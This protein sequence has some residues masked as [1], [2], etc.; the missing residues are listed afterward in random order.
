M[1]S[2]IY[3][4]SQSTTFTWTL[5]EGTYLITLWC[6]KSL[7][8]FPSCNH[9]FE[10]PV[11][12][13]RRHPS[14]WSRIWL[15]Y[16]FLDHAPTA[17]G[18]GYQLLK[19]VI[20]SWFSWLLLKTDFLAEEFS[21]LRINQWCTKV[22]NI[23]GCYGDLY[24]FSTHDKP[25]HNVIDYTLHT[26]GGTVSL[27]DNNIVLLYTCRKQPESAVSEVCIQNIAEWE[28]ATH[29]LPNLVYRRLHTSVWRYKVENTKLQV[30]SL[31]AWWYQNRTYTNNT[32]SLAITIV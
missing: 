2:H 24:R 23:S 15:E 29:T 14:F 3:C 32:H 1:C 13:G 17:E 7:E 25:Q 8:C 4:F 28:M 5:A 18:A 10:L 27:H 16:H 21:Y 26:P 30:I 22:N 11:T 19:W 12:F 31:C 6:Q 20:T 9:I